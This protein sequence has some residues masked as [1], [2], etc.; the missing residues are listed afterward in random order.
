MKRVTEDIFQL[1]RGRSGKDNARMP[2][3]L[4]HAFKVKCKVDDEFVFRGAY[5]EVVGIA[6]TTRWRRRNVVRIVC[7]NALTGN[8]TTKGE[9]DD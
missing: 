3:W 9:A 7:H 1:M 4:V 2:A 6:P 8:C 5:L